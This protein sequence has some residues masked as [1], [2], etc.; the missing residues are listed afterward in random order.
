MGVFM[1]KQITNIFIASSFASILVG[2]ASITTGQSQTMSVN[3]GE[4]SEAS[5]SLTNDKGTWY[6]NSTPGA[7][8]VARSSADLIIGC[9]KGQKVGNA[10]LKSSTKGMVFGNIIA[11]G[12]LGAIVDYSTGAAY[13]Y[14][15]EI[16]VPLSQ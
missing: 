7:V 9:K 16:C 4:E 5:C 8:D 10:T 11:G 12:G 1:V 6:I 3:T 15:E 14:P 13:E 2:C